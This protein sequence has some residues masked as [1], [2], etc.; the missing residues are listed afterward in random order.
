MKSY[1]TDTVAKVV[2]RE[3]LEGVVV[4]V[5]LAKIQSNYL[6]DAQI[7]FFFALPEGG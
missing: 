6:N 1:F 2:Y 7:F 4:V 5:V 3:L